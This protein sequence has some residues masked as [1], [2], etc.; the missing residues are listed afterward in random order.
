MKFQQL[1]FLTL[2]ATA[3]LSACGPG[4]NG[5]SS[6][7]QEIEDRNQLEK[8]YADVVGTY[9]GT[10]TSGS[11]DN[12]AVYPVEVKINLVYVQDG[13][14]EKRELKFRPELRANFR[15]LD[16]G[17]D[18]LFARALFVRY[19]KEDGKIVMQN[20]DQQP[21]NGELPGSQFFSVDGFFANGRI[22]GK[23]SDK[24]GLLGAL[25]LSRAE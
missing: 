6:T 16:L 20:V 23:A 8:T 15:R 12:S 2:A 11:A 5:A 24:S 21:K 17:D 22:I 9:R 19:Y 7:A 14:N 25:D 1:V 10:L 18:A 3:L 4:M 13:V